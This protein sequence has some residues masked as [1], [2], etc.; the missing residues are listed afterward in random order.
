VSYLL[1]HGAS[2]TAVNNKRQL[3]SDIAKEDCL[4]LLLECGAPAADPEKSEKGATTIVPN[5]IQHPP[6]FYATAGRPGNAGAE[7]TPKQPAAVAVET[8]VPAVQSVQGGHVSLEALLH[9]LEVQQ[10]STAATIQLVHALRV[11]Q[12]L[13]QLQN[14]GPVEAV[15]AAATTFT[16]VHVH[17][18]SKT[19]VVAGVGADTTLG[20]VMDILPPLS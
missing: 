6:F 10:Q 5:Y 8:V 20:D 17:F 16:D 18:G 3:A 1:Q 9:H 19:K 11:Q 14:L 12:Q 4:P 7:P 13:Q 2:L 15:A